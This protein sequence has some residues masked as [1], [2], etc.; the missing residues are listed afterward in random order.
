VA[1]ATDHV[2]KAP[3]EVPEDLITLNEA[4]ALLGGVTHFTIRRRISDGSLT[5]YRFGPKV[6]RVSRSQVLGLV[7]IVPAAGA[8]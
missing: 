6:L 8:R 2:T 5:G 1:T 3:V 7:S 4:G